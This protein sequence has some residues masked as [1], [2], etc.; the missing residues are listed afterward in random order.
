MKNILVIMT[1]C[2]CLIGAGKA[3]SNTSEPPSSYA[4]LFDEICQLVE[5]H[6]YNTSLIQETF[7]SIKTGYRKKIETVSTQTEFS[8]LVNAM[9]K[10][11]KTS[12]TYYLSPSDY[13]YY[14]LAAVFSALPAIQNLFPDQDM[15]Y[16]TVGII[17]ET[18]EDHNFIVSVLPGSA[19]EHAGL[20]AGD[21]IVA[22]NGAP[23][24]PIDSLK[25]QVGKDVKFTIRRRLGEN[26]RTFTLTPV[27]VD[28]RIE[29]L[30]AEKASIRV[31][32]TQ[33]HNIG[34]IHIYS[35]A[36]QEYHDE[37]VSA[38]SWGALQD[39]E[40]LI[41]DLRYG[42]GGADPT[43]LN[44]FNPHVP[45]ITAIDRTGKTHHYD[46]QWRKPAVFL[47]NHATR[48]GKEILAFGA[49]KYKLATVIGERTAGAVVG[50]SL[51]PLSNGD[52]LYLACQGSLVDGEKLEG[53][54]VFP[55]I[56]VPM[57]IR[58]C[59]GKDTQLVSA[60]EYILETLM[61]RYMFRSSSLYTKQ[62]I[63]SKTAGSKA[64]KVS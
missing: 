7:P 26:A 55:D 50:G 24:Q 59:Q 12:H 36:G 37:L 48:S 13:E 1:A 46:P 17:T 57:D 4:V 60:V 25:N 53:V 29:M 21:E 58:Y 39:A 9:L 54:G 6:F 3:S 28:P 44:I 52:L 19:A 34:Y 63:T 23:Y 49:K 42:L 47:V 64:P 62:D 56:D 35:Y 40:A 61:P 2:I 11:F 27:S 8:A 41:I 45:V 43:Y 15:S 10:Q 22:V 33:G 30:E 20:M 38:I 31:I 16:P 51:F 14:H 18:I 32:E 5:E